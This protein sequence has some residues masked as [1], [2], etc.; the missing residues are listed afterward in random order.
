[1]SKIITTMFLSVLIAL[2]L[3]SI[4]E[5]YYIDTVADTKGEY[6]VLANIYAHEYGVSAKKMKQVV[7]CESGWRANAKNITEREMSYGLSQ[8]NLK[9][10]TRISIEQA[11]DPDFAL[12]FMAKEFKRGNARIW[13]CAR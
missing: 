2:G 3:P 7:K 8:L 10:H 6:M 9:A 5:S 12:E 13:T 1:M 4:T 11:T